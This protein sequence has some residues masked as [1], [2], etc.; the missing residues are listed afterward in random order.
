[1]GWPDQV[2]RY[3]FPQIGEGLIAL[4]Q[5]IT[6]P[7]VLLKAFATVEAMTAAL[8]PRWSLEPQAYFMADDGFSAHPLRL[9]RA[10]TMAWEDAGAARRVKILTDDGVTAAEGRMVIVGEVAVYDR[11]ATHSDHRRR[12]LG[13][14]VMGA[15][16]EAAQAQG[17]RRGLLNA[18]A[19]GRA[20]YAALGW[21]LVSLYATAL[22]RNDG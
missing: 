22:I 9:P 13:S 6:E 7:F 15:L 8:P 5:S 3:V 19:E 10:Y 18:T 1:M 21:R 4:A 12:R 17:A 11:I 2:R 20:L 14:T 16:G